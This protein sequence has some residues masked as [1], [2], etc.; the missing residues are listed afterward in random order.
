[1]KKFGNLIIV[2]LIFIVIFSIFIFSKDINIIVSFSFNLWKENI[3]P[4]LFPFFVISNVLVNIGFVEFLGSLLKNIMYILF[5]IKGEASF[6]FF[7]GMLSG[8]PS[9]AKYIDELNKKGL[10][11]E[12]ESNKLILFTFFSNPLFVIN[13]IGIMFFKDI[14]IGII[15]LI[16]HYIGNIIIGIL[17]RNYNA[18]LKDK[19]KIDI[20][21]T[22][23]L[24]NEN[25]GKTKFFNTIF[26]AA[27]D[28]VK[29][30][31]SI[32]ATI[33]IFL[34]LISIISNLFKFNTLENSIIYGIFE[35]TS[36]LRQLSILDIALTT[37]VFLS[38][39]FISFGGLSI[40]AQI[41][42]I[43]KNYNINYYRFL[44]VRII[45]GIMSGAI[46]LLI[47]NYIN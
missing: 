42:N 9:S 46:A 17:F 13:T 15:I 1:M 35:M 7:M 36:G 3:F 14:K 27:I 18:S 24:F 25:I 33:T 34:I 30:L 11:N 5:K 16:A 41:I 45:H 20:K 21:K 4:S 43:L 2:L 22:L 26:N 28:S 38:T 40:H 10:L 12:S 37:K 6:V 29:T 44:L 47:L 39:F 19:K 31:V 8:F 23:C 32:F